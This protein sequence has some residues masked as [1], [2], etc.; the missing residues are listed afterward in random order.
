[1]LKTQKLREH[2]SRTERELYGILQRKYQLMRGGPQGARPQPEHSRETSDSNNVQS[3]K[4]ILSGDGPNQV[5]PTP[6]AAH[7][8]SEET[9]DLYNVSSF[10]PFQVTPL[11]LS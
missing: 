5:K 11:S 7:V 6:L 8:P 1:V 2:L 3:L 9:A 4:Q 10:S